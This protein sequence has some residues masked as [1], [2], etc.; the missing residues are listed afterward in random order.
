[1]FNYLF[2][3][4]KASIIFFVFVATFNSSISF[5][6]QE[7]TAFYD[8]AICNPPYTIRH[9]TEINNEAEKLVKPD[10][11]L[12]TAYVYKLPFDIGRD[13]FKTNEVVFSGTMVGVLIDGWRADELAKH[14]Q[15]EREESNILGTS[16]KGYA[17]VVPPDPEKPNLELGRVSIIARESNAIPGK[18]IL[19]C[20]F[21]SDA[22]L[23][24]LKQLDKHLHSTDIQ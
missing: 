14:Y 19:G 20:E 7:G 23:D 17:R 2:L 1:M 6:S 10:T 5:A 12:M 13:G 24:R 9:A 21:V 16:L 8:A 3:Q 18:T 4:G 11:S 22:D 15:L